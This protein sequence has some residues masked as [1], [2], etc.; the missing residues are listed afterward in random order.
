MDEVVLALR[1]VVIAEGLELNGG[2]DVL[3]DSSVG[4]FEACGIFSQM[5]RKFE[6]SGYENHNPQQ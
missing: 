1:G 6:Q 4:R 3:V 2:N 5:V